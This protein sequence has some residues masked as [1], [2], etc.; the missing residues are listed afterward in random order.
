MTHS[1]LP[2]RQP[3]YFLFDLPQF[4]N[5]LFIIFFDK[6]FIALDQALS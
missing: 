4:L 6:I 2:H 3:A 1:I 5:L